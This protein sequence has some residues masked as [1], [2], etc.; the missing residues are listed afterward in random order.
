VIVRQAG[1]PDGD[2]IDELIA[3]AFDGGDAELEIVRAIRARGI[4]LPGLELVAEDTDGLIGHVLLSEADL[5]GRS[6]PAVAP[7][8][9]RPDR[10]R[11]GLGSVLMNEVL[12][13]AEGQAWPLVALLGHPSYYPRFGFEP[14]RPIGIVYPP[15]DSPAFMVRRLSAYDPSWRGRFRFGWEPSFVTRGSTHRWRHLCTAQREHGSVRLQRRC[16]LSGGHRPS[17]PVKTSRP[18]SGSS[19]SKTATMEPPPRNSA[20]VPLP[21]TTSQTDPCTKLRCVGA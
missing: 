16:G 1:H 6:V 17:D 2:A 12:A 20:S 21:S 4:A 14:G 13:L 7:L 19:L 15:V 11:S 10:Q 18:R 8:S 9:V 5:G 3:A